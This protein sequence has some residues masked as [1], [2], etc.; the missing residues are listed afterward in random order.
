M[1]YELFLSLRYLRARRREVFVSLI[2][3]ISMIGVMIG[4]LTLNIVLAVMTGFEK[5]CVIVFWD[6]IHMW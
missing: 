2:T 5:T 3:M 6:L 4:V 1:R